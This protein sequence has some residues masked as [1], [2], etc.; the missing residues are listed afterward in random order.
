[1]LFMKLVITNEQNPFPCCFLLTAQGYCGYVLTVH[2]RFLLPANPSIGVLHHRGKYYGFSS[3]EAAD[4]FA[5]N[6]EGSVHLT[7]QFPQSS[8]Y[9]CNW[10]H[11]TGHYSFNTYT[12][13]GSFV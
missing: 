13:S 1:M 11:V 2:D 8:L 6:P 9:T 12:I 5:G 3:K 4:D 10:T 7:V